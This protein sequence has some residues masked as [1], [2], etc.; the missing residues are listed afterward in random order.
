MARML[1]KMGVTVRLGIV[2]DARRAVSAAAV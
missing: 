2:G 1:Q